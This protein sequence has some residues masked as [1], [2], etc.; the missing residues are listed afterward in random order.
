[1]FIHITQTFEIQFV[2]DKCLWIKNIFSKGFKLGKLLINLKIM[3]I[4]F[5]NVAL[6]ITYC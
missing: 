3:V 1:M 4:Y 2:H 6:H 5:L